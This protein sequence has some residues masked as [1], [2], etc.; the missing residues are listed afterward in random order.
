[1]AGK[2]RTM[3]RPPAKWVYEFLKNRMDPNTLLTGKQI[4]EKYSLASARSV[5]DF[6]TRN[7]I[8][9]IHEKGSDRG[10]VKKFRVGDIKNALADIVESYEGSAK[11]QS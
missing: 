3:G 4:A 2:K 1:M 6:F 11:G 10:I 9:G 5:T 7:N 8:P